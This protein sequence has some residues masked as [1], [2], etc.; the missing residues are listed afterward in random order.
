MAETRNGEF[1][2][3]GMWKSFGIVEDKRIPRFVRLDAAMRS[4]TL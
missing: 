3:E 2:A 1:A 4:A